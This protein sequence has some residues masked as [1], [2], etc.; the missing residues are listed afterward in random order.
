MVCRY[1][2]TPTIQ[3]LPYSILG[4]F[5]FLLLSSTVCRLMLIVGDF[6]V[7][8]RIGL[9]DELTDPLLWKSI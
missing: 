2:N 4:V 7:L 8:Y 1:D 9:A 5:P 6:S 3:Y